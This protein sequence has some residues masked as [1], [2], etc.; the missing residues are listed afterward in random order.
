[1][2][3]LWALAAL[4]VPQMAAA[5]GGTYEVRQGD[6]VL[7]IAAQELGDPAKW[8]VIFYANQSVIDAGRFD[9]AV[10]TRLQIPCLPGSQQA[11]PTPLLDDNAEMKLVTG[12]DYAPFTDRN[13]PG[14]GLVTELVNA[15]ME[16]TPSPVS[17]SVTWEDDWS[18][19]LFPMLDSK[20]FDMGFPWLRP[21]CEEAPDNE[22]CANFHFSEPLVE[23]LIL[24]FTRAGDEFAYDTDA[25]IEGKTLCRPKGYFTHDL[26]RSGR[27]WLADGKITLVQAESPTACFEALMAGQVDAVT[28]NEFL[29][30]TK[31]HDLGLVGRVVPLQRPLSVEGLH[32]LISK[33]HWRG[34]THL[35]RFN[36]GLA[37]LKQSARYDEIVARH[38]AVFYDRLKTQ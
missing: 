5:C 35:Y 29:G 9:V 6:T 26:D 30:V 18:K 11:D 27:R 4:F 32:V 22:R 25:D 3:W 28:I 19:H 7:S 34:T 14:N 23:L 31:I 38:L 33:K 15:A 12:T 13:W 16:E 17:Y 1:M 10:G 20:Q 2:R 21:N 36:A 24:L 37:K 8:S